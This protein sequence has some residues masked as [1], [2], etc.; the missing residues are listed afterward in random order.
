MIRIKR[1]LCRILGHRWFTLWTA[2]GGDTF[3]DGCYRCG[4]EVESPYHK[5]ER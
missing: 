5:V 4:L 1:L 3:G 2:G